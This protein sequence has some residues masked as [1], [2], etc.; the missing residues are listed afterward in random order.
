M[1]VQP[2]FADVR[3]DGSSGKA[4]YLSY[5]ADVACMIFPILKIILNS[6]NETD[7]RLL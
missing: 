1:P 4:Q 7:R 2:V 5:L 6:K 3:H